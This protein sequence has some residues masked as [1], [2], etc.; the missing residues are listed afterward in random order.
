[1]LTV[2]S[3]RRTHRADLAVAFGVA[4]LVAAGVALFLGAVGG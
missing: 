1:M 2:G 4:L 3:L